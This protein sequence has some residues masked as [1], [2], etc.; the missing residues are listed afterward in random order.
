ESLR[1][2]REDPRLQRLAARIAEKRLWV[3]DQI[4]AIAKGEDA[5]ASH[6]KFRDWHQD[7]LFY[8]VDLGVLAPADRVRRLRD[9]AHAA[10]GLYAA[11]SRAPDAAWSLAD[12]LPTALSEAEK[13]RVR[14]GCYDLLLSESRAAVDPAEGLRILDRAV[15]LRPEMTPAYHL[16]R[17]ECLDRL[18]DVA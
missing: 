16:C 8:A 11:D 7:A 6:Q 15:R 3:T 9:S 18:G 10:L 17:A 2:S 14:E 5:T 1:A 13:T 4:L 12:T